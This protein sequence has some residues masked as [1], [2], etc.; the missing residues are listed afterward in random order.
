MAMTEREAMGR[1]LEL[2]QRGWGRVAPNPLVGAVLLRDGAVVGEGFHAEFGGAHAEVAA[3]RQCD[4]PRDTTCVLNLEPCA[5]DAKTPPCADALI[6]AGVR[7]VVYALP[8]PDPVAGGGGARL[9]AA[10]VEIASGLECERAAALNAPFLWSRCRPDLPFVA[11]KVATSIDGFMADTDG[12]SRWVSSETAREWVHWLRA[13]FD[14]IAVGRNTAVVDDPALTVR[15]SVAPRVPPTR[16]VFA[17]GGDLPPDL[18]LVATARD[19][20]T[21]IFVRTGATEPTRTALAGSAATVHPADDLGKALRTLRGVG[22]ESVLVEGGGTV[23]TALLEADLVDRLYW[24]QAPFWLGGGR[25]AFGHRTARRLADVRP[26]HVIERRDLGPD[27]LLVLD[28]E[29]C[30][31]EL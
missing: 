3:L 6:D 20:P 13:G 31:P 5:H 29:L 1:A 11:V 15:G 17:G 9:A 22:I 12:S 24:V 10:G 4:D 30:L 28:R 21:M 16:V 23:V 27:T 7:R 14:A 18:A 8:D 25:A 26:W 2:A 19:V